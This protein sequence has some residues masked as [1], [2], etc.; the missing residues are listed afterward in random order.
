MKKL[1][2]HGLI[3]LAGKSVLTRAIIVAFRKKYDK[4]MQVAVTA[5][6]GVAANNI[7]GSTVHSVSWPV[8]VH[9]PARSS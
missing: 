7:G 2:S 6:T 1:P 9:T 8:F 3:V 5:T 4:P